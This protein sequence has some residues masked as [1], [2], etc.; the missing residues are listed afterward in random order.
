MVEISWINL[1]QL[2]DMVFMQICKESWV[3]LLGCWHY[4]RKLC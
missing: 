2:V 1:E 4:S 3:M